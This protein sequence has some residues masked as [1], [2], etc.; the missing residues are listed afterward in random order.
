MTASFIQLTGKI[1]TTKRNPCVICLY[2]INPLDKQILTKC[3]HA[4]HF[5]CWNTYCTEC[6]LNNA[7]KKP[8]C[9][10]TCPN[11]RETL[12]DFHALFL[13]FFDTAIKTQL[14][15]AYSIDNVSEPE[16]NKSICRFLVKFFQKRNLQSQ[17][18]FPPANT[19]AENGNEDT[20]NQAFARQIAQHHYEE[21]V[22]FPTYDS[23]ETRELQLRGGPKCCCSLM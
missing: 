22:T 14:F 10:L 13:D 2:D 16:V 4:F 19:V 23:Y 9:V 17:S 12:V 20:G 7:P 5:E 18:Y 15:L 8:T 21:I 11:C 6:I 1:P 3:F